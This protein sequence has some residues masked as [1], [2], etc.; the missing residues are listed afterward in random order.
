MEGAELAGVVGKP[1]YSLGGAARQWG[2]GGVVEIDE[3]SGDGEF[4]A[5]AGGEAGHVYD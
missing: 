4:G 1:A 5:V 2:Y 3:L